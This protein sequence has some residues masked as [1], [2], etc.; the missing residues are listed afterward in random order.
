MGEARL[1]RP[2]FWGSRVERGEVL[3]AEG[4]QKVVAVVGLIEQVHY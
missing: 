2:P 3:K 4:L 1:E